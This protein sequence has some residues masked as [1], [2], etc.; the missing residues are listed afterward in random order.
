MKNSLRLNSFRHTKL[1]E[2]ITVHYSVFINTAIKLF[3]QGNQSCFL[4]LQLLIFLRQ[5]IL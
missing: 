3:L 2:N 1:T 4:H 5:G